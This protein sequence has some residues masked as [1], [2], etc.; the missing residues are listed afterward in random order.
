MSAAQETLAGLLVT[1]LGVPAEKVVPT[2]AYKDLALDSLALIELTML[3]NKELDISLGDDLLQGG[4]TIGET[5][6]LIDSQGVRA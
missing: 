2:A 6:E 4:T 5:V 1:K 3:L